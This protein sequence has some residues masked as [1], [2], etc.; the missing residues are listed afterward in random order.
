[1]NDRAGFEISSYQFDKRLPK[2]LKNVSFA[3]QYWPIVYL[4]SNGSSRHAY[5]GETSDAVSRMLAHFRNAA[6]S[7]LNRAYLISSEKFNKSATLDIESKLIK[8]LDGDGQYKLLNAN[9]GLSNH[10]YYQK[11]DLYGPLFQ[12][13]WES[14]RD[15]KIVR[16]ALDE[17]DNLDTFKYSPFKT[18]SRDQLTGVKAILESLVKDT[19][20][21]T[22]IEGGAGTGKSVMAVYLFKLLNTTIDEYD[23]QRLESDDLELARL[24]LRFRERYPNPKMALIVA[25]SSFRAT[26]KKVFRHVKDL[27][28]DMVIGPADLARQSYDLLVVDESHRLRRRTNL[29]TYFRAFDQAAETMGFD[30]YCTNELEWVIHRS[31][32]AVFFYD[33]YQ[34]VRPSDIGES[35]FVQLRDRLDTNVINLFGQF[36]VAGG[37]P[38][39]RFLHDLL[40]IRN[41]ASIST[42]TQN[43]N[44]DLRLFDHLPE[45]RDAIFEKEKQYGLCRLVAGYAWPW[46]SKKNK[47]VYD[48]NIDGLQLRWNGTNMDWVNSPNAVHEVGCIHTTQGYDLNYTG[49]IF[50]PEI[51]YDPIKE[52][53]IIHEMRYHDRSGKATVKDPSE[54]RD[55][56]LNIYRT[57]M[58]RGIRGTYVYVCNPNLREYFS[59]YMPVAKI[60]SLVV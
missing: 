50:G 41:R 54:L 32:R 12:E 51:D 21:T 55:Y 23:L 44:Y 30:K 3:Q 2:E 37:T 26:L 39:V 15:L 53:I 4:L 47:A 52:E 42:Y 33:K 17:I 5:V 35:V 16:H 49:V 8:Y 31:K 56:I 29:G 9:L 60:P 45:M 25:M 28:P 40:Y 24:A 1:M 58:L 48:I 20:R 11:Y 19:H 36:R 57:L 22:L 59:K 34:T 38:Y 18:L 43:E 6:K 14:L 27:H 46:L 10:N 13:I 7:K